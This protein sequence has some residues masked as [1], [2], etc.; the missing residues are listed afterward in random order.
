MEKHMN[1]VTQLDGERIAKDAVKRALA[2]DAMAA[3]AET[4][5]P[6]TLLV[7]VVSSAMT[8][9]I[10]GTKDEMIFRIIVGALTGATF[11]MACLT[12]ADVRRLRRRVEAMNFL[13]TGKG[14]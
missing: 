10:L 7:V 14:L 9:G 3:T 11:A 8:C 2:V 4:V 6:L 13:S 1:I 5:N 12:Y